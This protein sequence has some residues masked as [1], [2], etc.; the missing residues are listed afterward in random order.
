MG[1]YKDKVK[2]KW[3]VHIRYRGFP[4]VSMYFD[5]YKEAKNFHEDCLKKIRASIKKRK[6]DQLGV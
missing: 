4:P 2:K 5:K 3:R 1:L 6:V